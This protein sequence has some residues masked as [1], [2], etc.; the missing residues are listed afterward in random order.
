[1]KFAR[2]FFFIALLG[3]R[4]GAATATCTSDGKTDVT[5]CLQNALNAAQHRG[6]SQLFLPFGTYLVSQTIVV[7]SK[8][9][10]IGAGRGDRNFIGTVIL[11]SPTFPL[12]GTL[13]KM[14]PD[15]LNNFGVQVKSMTLD[16]NG[17]ADVCLQNKWS[18]EQSYGQDLLLTD[19][20]KAGLDVEGGGAQNSGP[21]TD[22]EIYPGGGV[23]VTNETNC[24]IVSNVAAFRGIHGVTCNAG[25][26]Y[27]TRPNV[28]LQLDGA[29]T[30]SDIHVEHF[31]TAARLGSNYDSAD[32]LIFMNGEF[33]PDVDTGLLIDN[34]AANQNLSIF[35]ISCNGCTTVLNDQITSHS[36]PWSVGFYLVGNGAGAGKRVLTSD[37]SI[38]EAF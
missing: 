11:A 10:L 32:G 29:G 19:F 16:G 27:L 20:M 28:A 15:G 12:H 30:Y 38:A 31:G 5:A 7:P 3:A 34:I 18:M 37:K 21:F 4:L 23:T 36:T 2:Y 22:L 24:I 35:G 13:L 33:G 17:R 6:D 1:M 14:G 8:V 25:T 9:Q 26:A